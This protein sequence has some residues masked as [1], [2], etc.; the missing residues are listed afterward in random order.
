MASDWITHNG[1]GDPKVPG[2]TRVEVKFRDG[3]TR[4]G[5]MH[6]W[7]QNWQWADNEDGLTAAGVIVAYRIL[8]T[9]GAD[10]GQ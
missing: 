8:P 10:N 6:D 9:L 1:V 4:F 2:D 5:V 7:D 3:E